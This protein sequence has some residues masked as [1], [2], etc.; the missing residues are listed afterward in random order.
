MRH[1]WKG[2]RGDTRVASFFCGFCCAAEHTSTCTCA[3][4]ACLRIFRC[5]AAQQRVCARTMPEA[6]AARDAVLLSAHLL[7]PLGVSWSWPP[8]AAGLVEPTL[9][10]FCWP[11]NLFVDRPVGH[12]FQLSDPRRVGMVLAWVAGPAEANALVVLVGAPY[13]DETVLFE[14]LLLAHE[15]LQEAV[16]TATSSPIAA[17]SASALADAHVA[18]LLSSLAGLLATH[19]PPT[20]AIARSRET[21][22]QALCRSLRPAGL[23]SALLSVLL[24]EHILLVSQEPMLLFRA[25]LALSDAIAPLDFCGALVPF[26]PEGLHPDLD[27][28]LNGAVEPYIVGMHAAL[29]AKVAHELSETILTVD[30]DAA[31]VSGG[32]GGLQADGLGGGG[33]GGG[34]NTPAAAAKRRQQWLRTSV[35]ADASKQLLHL[36]AAGS[37]GGAALGGDEHAEHSDGGGGGE[38]TAASKSAS[39]VVSSGMWDLPRGYWKGLRSS[40]VASHGLSGLSSPSSKHPP[41]VD[42]S[43]AVSERDGSCSGGTAVAAA[44]AATTSSFGAV[45]SSL[46]QRLASVDSSPLRASSAPAERLCWEQMVAMSRLSSAVLRDVPLSEQQTAELTVVLSD[47]QVTNA[48]S[49][50]Q[51]PLGSLLGVLFATRVYREHACRISSREAAAAAA[52]DPTRRP[53][54]ILYNAEDSTAFEATPAPT[55]VP[56]VAAGCEE[57][58]PSSHLLPAL[59]LAS[60]SDDH[61]ECGE[62]TID[63][64]GSH[65]SSNGSSHGNSH[66]KG[67]GNGLVSNG[68]V[69]DVS[70]ESSRESRGGSSSVPTPSI[71]AAWFAADKQL[72]ALLGGG[73]SPGGAAPAFAIGPASLAACITH[74]LGFHYFETFLASATRTA[75]HVSPG[76]HLRP[77]LLLLCLQLWMALQPAASLVVVLLPRRAGRRPGL[78]EAARVAGQILVYE[79]PPAVAKEIGKDEASYGDGEGVLRWPAEARRALDTLSQIGEQLGEAEAAAEAAAEAVGGVVDSDGEDEADGL[80]EAAAAAAKVAGD[81][82]AAKVAGYRAAVAKAASDAAQRD[83]TI[84]ALAPAALPPAA[85]PTGFESVLRSACEASLATSLGAFA[86]SAQFKLLSMNLA[87]KSAALV[88]PGATPSASK[89]EM[90]RPVAL[91]VAGTSSAAAADGGVA[92][93]GRSPEC[94]LRLPD[95]ASDGAAS[96]CV[97][98]PVHL[99]LHTGPLSTLAVHVPLSPALGHAS[100]AAASAVAGA[101][102][103][104][105]RR[106][107]LQLLLPEDVLWLGLSSSHPVGVQ[108][109]VNRICNVETRATLLTGGRPIPL[110]PA[111]RGFAAG[112]PAASPA[113]PL[114]LISSHLDPQHSGRLRFKLHRQSSGVVE[115]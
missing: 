44:A 51:T 9:A 89:S 93:V 105:G 86:T 103:L 40:N 81:A 92:S 83:E 13:A 35:L 102:Y 10:S 75:A 43:V 70:R 79:A 90:P 52:A 38:R 96:L 78:A 112:A 6:P 54:P 58:R 77:A 5:V 32:H 108:Y 45:L 80:E 28:L 50:C 27:T 16:A 18:P 66:G 12:A 53:L 74:P 2:Q 69:V 95:H 68:R 91:S 56:M 85:L 76:R 87:A 61:D 11:P 109:R 67:N 29:H 73:F 41:A 36:L 113:R 99:R 39:G 107:R 3:C 33:G 97:G 47:Q 64:E 59:L 71:V 110:P 37:G 17:A 48:L 57:L 114:S 30:L 84:A 65:S 104:S 22:V 46:S 111:A 60:A 88:G 63:G 4:A 115:H 25:S 100:A 14:T 98:G 7:G 1:T 26:L 21:C 106:V 19:A 42:H 34:G 72:A 62:G 24:E 23:L 15:R 55:A 49:R 101:T 94:A 31:T 20:E 8:A 82:A